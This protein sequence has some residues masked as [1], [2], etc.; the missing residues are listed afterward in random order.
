MS[1]SFLEIAKM[2]SSTL[3]NLIECTP[4]Y[5]SQCQTKMFCASMI[6][7]DITS[8]LILIAWFIVI[9]VYN[10]NQINFHFEKY[11]PIYFGI[12]LGTLS[13]YS[14][15]F[16][17]LSFFEDTSDACFPQFSYW[18]TKAYFGKLIGIVLLIIAF[19]VAIL[20]QDFY[21]DMVKVNLENK[22]KEA[23]LGIGT[24]LSSLSNFYEENGSYM[25]KMGLYDVELMY[26]E[27]NF[28][29]EFEKVQEQKY[30]QCVVC[31]DDSFEKTDKVI[32]MPGCLHTYHFACI[33]EW[34]LKKPICPMCKSNF[35]HHIVQALQEKRDNS[36]LIISSSIERDD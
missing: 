10:I 11:L 1:Y 20:I 9:I 3:S 16:I 35:R 22:L 4:I 25:G 32:Q 33:K 13:V 12:Y 24:D 23:Y 21:E 7:H 29:S 5:Q 31:F 30:D 18:W 8:Y 2:I 19:V 27:D 15:F 17:D 36:V 14:F 6:I 28:E 34:L 26:F